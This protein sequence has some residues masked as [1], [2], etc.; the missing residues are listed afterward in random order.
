MLGFSEDTLSRVGKRTCRH[1]IAASD[2]S[3]PLDVLG[4]AINDILCVD[5][6][7]R[8]ASGARPVVKVLSDMQLRFFW[9]DK[10]TNGMF[11]VVDLED[12]S[13]VKM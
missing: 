13:L 10:M 12:D 9:L 5:S 4:A 7:V 6:V 3:D 8:P 11:H 2:I 1:G